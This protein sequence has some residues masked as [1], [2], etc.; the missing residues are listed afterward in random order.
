MR[1]KAGNWIIAANESPLRNLINP[2]SAQPEMSGRIL[3]DRTGLSGK[4]SFTLQWAPQSLSGA[5]AATEASGPSLFTAL[6]EQLGLRREST[7][8]PVE[9]LV[10]DRVERPSPN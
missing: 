4:Y 5:G 10:I 1:M 9:V 8:A 3:L 2:L 6:E 7:K